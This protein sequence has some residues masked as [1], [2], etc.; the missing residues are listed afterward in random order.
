MTPHCLPWAAQ[1]L[2]GSATGNSCVPA[3]TR[4]GLLANEL[5]NGSFPAQTPA[6]MGKKWPQPATQNSLLQN[7]TSRA[8]CP[9]GGK[10]EGPA[11]SRSRTPRPEGFSEGPRYLNLP[12]FS[13]KWPEAGTPVSKG[14]AG[15]AGDARPSSPPYSPG[16]ESFKP[17]RSFTLWI[18]SRHMACS[19]LKMQSECMAVTCEGHMG[20]TVG[21]SREVHVRALLPKP[22]GQCVRDGEQ[23]QE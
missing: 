19:F 18:F 16:K 20:W 21:A 11:Q 5:S 2:S 13:T 12:Q 15:Y 8:G 4:P 6:P 22:Q 10:P 3:A 9:R 23:K 7:E 14:W 1:V 17:I